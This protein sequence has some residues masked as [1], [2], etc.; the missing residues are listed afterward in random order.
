MAH[1]AGLADSRAG[2]RTDDVV[3]ALRLA[4]TS[5]CWISMRKHRTR[6]VDLELAGI[7]DDLAGAGLQPDAGDGVPATVA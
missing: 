6:E 2:D 5:G 1:R 4:A 3:L 7:D